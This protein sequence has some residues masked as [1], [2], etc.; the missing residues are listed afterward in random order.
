MMIII[1]WE[2]TSC[3]S[4]KNR[5]FHPYNMNKEEGFCL[6]KSWKSLICT[7]K[8][9][10]KWTPSHTSWVLLTTSQYLVPLHEANFPPTLAVSNMAAYQTQSTTHSKYC[11][12]PNSSLI[13]LTLDYLRLPRLAQSSTSLCIYKSLQLRSVTCSHSCTLKMEAIRSSETSV[14]IRATRRHLP[15]DD[16]HSIKVVCRETYYGLNWIRIGSSCGFVMTMVKL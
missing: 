2:M 14:V 9:P 7:L 8:Y 13:P 3:G 16:N 12:T 1:F 10:G 11:Y 5:R 15:E 6:S 4:Y